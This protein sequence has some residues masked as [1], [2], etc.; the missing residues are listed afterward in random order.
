MNSPCSRRAF[1]RAGAALSLGT[2]TTSAAVAAE[3]HYRVAPEITSGASLAHPHRAVFYDPT[4]IELAL[5]RPVINLRGLQPM[6]SLRKFDWG[7]TSLLPEGRILREW[8]IV[9]EARTI[10]VAPGLDFPAWTYNGSV[11][12]PTLR[13]Q[14]GERL[15]I[16]FH[17]T[18]ESEHSL[19]FHGIHRADM[20]GV[21]VVGRGGSYIYEFDAGPSG[22]HLYHCHA[23]PVAMHM[24]RGMYGAFIVDPRR[25]RPDRVDEIVLV[26]GG[27]DLDA[28]GQNELYVVN[29]GANFYRDNAI[30]IRAG[31]LVRLYFVNVLEYDLINSVHL[32]AN[33]FKAYRTTCIDEP[34]EYTDIVTLCQADRRI[35][36]FVYIEA[37]RY[38][39]HAHQSKFAERGWMAH[40][41]VVSSSEQT[42]KAL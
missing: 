30:R 38:M 14:E 17:N 19:H 21:E 37:G 23:P 24:A 5:R 18:L 8:D 20:D 35:I 25:A 26:A 10:E 1:L 39:F 27:W 40:F 22:L 6:E 41:D 4:A 11:P 31:E 9:A 7:R 13:C 33:F 32:H 28:D 36:E 3:Q 29:G 12:G 42:G 34:G 15:R 2:A 16:H